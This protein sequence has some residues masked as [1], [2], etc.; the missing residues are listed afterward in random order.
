MINGKTVCVLILRRRV[1]CIVGRIVRHDSHR[2]LQSIL[3]A[4]RRLGILSIQVLPFLG[5]ICTASVRFL[6]ISILNNRDRVCI[7]FGFRLSLLGSLLIQEAY[8][9]RNGCGIHSLC[10]LASQ[11][12]ISRNGGRGF[13]E[14]G[15]VLSGCGMWF[16]WVSCRVWNI[17]DGIFRHVPDRDLSQYRLFILGKRRTRHGKPE[18]H[19]ECHH[20]RGKP[21]PVTPDHSGS[22][23][24]ELRNTTS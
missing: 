21:C 16:P 23:F 6:G 4:F 11:V 18:E 10:G 14:R 19:H 3:L 12:L 8:A 20:E 17:L 1:G 7:L 22:S 2:I 24:M 13:P 5:R 9:S 15:S